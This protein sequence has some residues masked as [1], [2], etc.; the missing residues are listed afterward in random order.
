MIEIKGSRS[1]DSGLNIT[2]LIDIVF[3]LLI[4]FLLAAFFIQ[5]EGM[6][7]KLPKGDGAP[8]QVEDEFVVLIDEEGRIFYDDQLIDMDRLGKK[9]RVAAERNA[10]L[11]VVVKADRATTMQTAV[12][13]METCKNAGAK[14]LVIAT[15]REG[16]RENE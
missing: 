5:P 2:P 9:V 1:A 16:A 13:V 4:F 12:S 15:E 14:K 6:D 10:N 7:V 8:V 3:L 11:V